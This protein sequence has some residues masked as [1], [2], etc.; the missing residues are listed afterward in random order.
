LDSADVRPA[1]CQ[2]CLR[3]FNQRTRTVTTS[4]FLNARNALTRKPRSCNLDSSS[5][6]WADPD[7]GTQAAKLSRKMLA[8]GVSRFHPM[9]FNPK[10]TLPWKLTQRVSTKRR[11]NSHISGKPTRSC[12]SFIVILEIAAPWVVPCARM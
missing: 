7:D 11:S 6:S 10:R 9:S 4:E 5:P 8:A 3:T 2:C 1:D 12:S